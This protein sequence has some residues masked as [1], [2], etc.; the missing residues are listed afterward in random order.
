MSAADP[1]GGGQG[2]QV[3]GAVHRVDEPSALAAPVELGAVG[4][5]RPR[6][7]RTIAVDGDHDPQP[8]GRDLELDVLGGIAILRVG[9]GPGSPAGDHRDSAGAGRCAPAEQLLKVVVA[10]PG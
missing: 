3:Q 6:G 1:V 9:Q 7:H 2:G 4:H 10:G 8:P 5:H